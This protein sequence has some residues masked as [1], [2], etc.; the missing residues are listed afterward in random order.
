MRDRKR[1]FAGVKDSGRPNWATVV[2]EPGAMILSQCQ[3]HAREARSCDGARLSGH[4]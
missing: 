4:P 2:S 1:S 3:L